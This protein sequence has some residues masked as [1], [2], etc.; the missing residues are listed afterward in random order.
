[1]ATRLSLWQTVGR[2][3]PAMPPLPWKT[4]GTIEPDREYFVMASMLP[5]KSYLRIPQFLRLTM[6]IRGQL[7]RSE[8]LVGY[9]LTTEIPSKRFLTL[10]AWSDEEHLNAFAAAMPH[11]EVM[12]K[13]RP[14][15]EPTTFVT[16]GAQASEL[17]V[18][19]KTARERIAAAKDQR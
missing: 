10:S 5:L 16:W 3:E 18:S 15:M 12:R 6:A 8:G 7:A 2:K 9:T 11:L 19:W 17:P 13:L 4:F 14:H 1:M